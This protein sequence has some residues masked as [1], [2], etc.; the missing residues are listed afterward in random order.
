MLEPLASKS[1]PLGLVTLVPDTWTA[2]SPVVIPLHVGPETRAYMERLMAEVPP[3]KRGVA[4]L[5]IDLKGIDLSV[6]AH[7][8]DHGIF[9]VDAGAAVGREWTGNVFAAA[10][11]RL[12]WR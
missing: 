12:E 2:P 10:E 8:W 4:K 5:V 7:V 9:D 6:G 1:L 11:I 3:D